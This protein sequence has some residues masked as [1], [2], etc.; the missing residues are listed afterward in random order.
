MNH[1]NMAA[2]INSAINDIKH[3]S[4]EKLQAQFHPRLVLLENFLIT[5]KKHPFQ[6]ATPEESSK[7]VAAF[8]RLMNPEKTADDGEDDV[9]RQA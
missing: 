1:A 2:Q 6:I 7:L 4:D 5:L 8:D 3:I 9:L